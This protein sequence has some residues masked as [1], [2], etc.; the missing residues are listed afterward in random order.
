LKLYSRSHRATAF[1]YLL[2][3]GLIY[4]TLLDHVHAPE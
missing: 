3:G 4:L 1:C 2:L